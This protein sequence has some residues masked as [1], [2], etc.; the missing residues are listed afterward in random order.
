MKKSR[1]KH[2]RFFDVLNFE[3][4]TFCR[5]KITFNEKWSE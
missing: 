4:S 2:D 1:A 5:L 3:N